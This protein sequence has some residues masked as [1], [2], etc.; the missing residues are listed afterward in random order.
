MVNID[1]F[2]HTMP[3]RHDDDQPRQNYRRDLLG[4]EVDFIFVYLI[5]NSGGKS[6]ESARI[7]FPIYLLRDV[8]NRVERKKTIREVCSQTKNF[9]TKKKKRKEEITSCLF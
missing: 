3:I 4:F 2:I 8:N 9:K 6:A 1:K 5:Y 7:K